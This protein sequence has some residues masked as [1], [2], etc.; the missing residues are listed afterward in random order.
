MWFENAYF[1]SRVILKTLSFSSRLARI[2]GLT[3]KIQPRTVLSAVGVGVYSRVLN[4]MLRKELRLLL[5]WTEVDTSLLHPDCHLL[6]GFPLSFL[7]ASRK[8]R[9]IVLTWV[10]RRVSSEPWET[11]GTNHC[12][13]YSGQTDLSVFWFSSLLLNNAEFLIS[14]TWLYL[15]TAL[16]WPHSVLLSVWLPLCIY[17]FSPSSVP[18]KFAS[19]FSCWSGLWPMTGLSDT[20]PA[21]L[22]GWDMN[23]ER[24]VN[25]LVR[26]W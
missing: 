10:W 14:L 17:S 11:T 26:V 15:M 3:W 12:Q 16:W 21:P 4:V 20:G 13:G 9:V 1:I 24:D 2:W 22:A 6:R 5:F 25:L 18:A 7:E 8:A 19:K 23:F